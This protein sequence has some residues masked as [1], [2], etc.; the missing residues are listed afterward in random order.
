MACGL[1]DLIRATKVSDGLTPHG[2]R[3]HVFDAISLSIALSSIAS[4]RSFFSLAF[5]SSSA[6]SRLAF[7]RLRS[8]YLAFHLYI[9]VLEILLAANIGRLRASFLLAQHP[10]D[11][12]FREPARLHVHPL[13]GDGL[14]SFLEEVSELRSNPPRSSGQTLLCKNCHLILTAT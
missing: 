11:L 8:P 14:S 2:G 7:D 4:A 9:V 10:D 12:L 13:A 5:S 6:F 1:V 3:H